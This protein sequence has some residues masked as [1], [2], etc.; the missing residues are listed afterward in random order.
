MVLS[1]IKDFH[2][3]RRN[4]SIIIILV[5]QPGIPFYIEIPPQ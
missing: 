4:P 2:H 3:V 5:L 1:R